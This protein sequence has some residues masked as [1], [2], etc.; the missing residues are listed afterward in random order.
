MADAAM[1]NCT[2][3]ATGDSSEALLQALVLL[4]SL[5][6]GCLCVGLAWLRSLLAKSA[7]NGAGAT[8]AEV[9]AAAAPPP[10]PKPVA[11][12]ELT[13]STAAA[14][15]EETGGCP[16][17]YDKPAPA[18][19]VTTSDKQALRMARVTSLYEDY[20]H[21][22][23]LTVV[24]DNP[25]TDNPAMEPCFAAAMHGIELAFIL[26]AEFVKDSRQYVVK[27][28]RMELVATDVVT[29]CGI[30][31]QI[32]DG[33]LEDEATVGANQKSRN[34]M[35]DFPF[36]GA[37]PTLTKEDTGF[38]RQSP[39][40]DMLI[41]AVSR[42][43]P[44]M[45]V[46]ERHSMIKVIR[47]I[48]GKIETSFS[49]WSVGIGW[50]EQLQQLRE[51]V[52]LAPLPVNAKHE[53]LN[54]A[55][56]VRPTSVANT[57]LRERYR[58]SEDF[59]FRSVHL[60]TEC[61][62]FI[63][64]DRLRSATD[65]IEKHGHWQNAAA[66]VRSAATILDY[67]GDH[68]MMLTSM[69]LRD[70]LHL[71]VEI[72]GTSGEGSSAVKSFR[73]LLEAL[74]TPLSDALLQGKERGE[75]DVNLKTA[76]LDLY[77]HPEREPGLY[78]YAKALEIVES[79]LLGGFYFRHFCLA[80]NVIGST[81]KGTM[82]K[83]VAAL[84]KTYEKQL[85]P[86]LD[87]TRAT[88]GAK[89][90]AELIQFKGRIMD[91]IERSRHSP[92]PENADDDPFDE[93][94][95]PMTKSILPPKTEVSP[96]VSPP[97]ADGRLQ[98]PGAS[99]SN[100]IVRRS[101]YSSHSVP[102]TLAE[103]AAAESKGMPD[104]AFLDHAWGK[105]PPAAHVAAIKRL[106]GLYAL[107][108]T[109]WDI[110]FMEIMPEAATHVKRLLGVGDGDSH[111]VEFCHN[112]HEITTRLLS[113]KLD[114]LLKV[115]SDIDE[116]PKTIRI[117]TT[118]TEF[119]SLTRQLNRFKELGERSQIQIE[120]VVIEPLATFPERFVAAAGVSGFDF[121]YASQCV[122]STQETIVPD[123]PTFITDLHAS[124]VVAWATDRPGAVFDALI[125]LDGYHGF[126]AIPTDL[127]QIDPAIPL[128]YI[129]GMLKHVASGANC[130]FMVAPAT[131]TL[132]P[133]L[134]GWLADPSVLA[135]ESDG[136]KLGSEV[137]YCPGL[138][139]MGGT[140]AFAPS[141]LTFNEV[142]RRWEERGIEV[143]RVHGHVMKLHDRFLAGL[144]VKQEADDSAPA[145]HGATA[146]IKLENLHSLL[147]RDSRS[148]TLVF[149]QPTA[150][151][152]KLV[153]ENLRKVHSI[154][155]DSRKTYVRV[156]FGFNHHPEEVD[157]LLR[158]IC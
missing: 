17:G 155:I 18:A 153:V 53:Y 78:G 55:V 99:R 70:Y 4:I 146:G 38:G 107:G 11:P 157:R 115:P 88:L 52:G 14:E 91:G 89:L 138:S 8:Q 112:S 33:E 58:H 84:K 7:A 144:K 145:E 92:S 90:D 65:Q 81:A 111:V 130:A 42:S 69:V 100:E 49:T 117:L 31:A 114:A 141:L 85:F 123:V 26:M 131:V 41:D 158:A 135:A 54:Y 21:L 35:Q 68:V 118:D 119:Y 56:L 24:W 133:M 108:N 64:L 93:A 106:Y 76:L 9:V 59:F 67:L 60:G 77:E 103:A 48:T 128:C 32:V 151:D 120:S 147:H 136:L 83:S 50:E 105:T 12:L 13:A 134:T 96:P 86:L 75:D 122:Y 116:A 137:G 47:N 97:K 121:V 22:H 80:S 43:F 150:A 126:G 95:K 57:L 73:P 140:P 113:T 143:T 152:A 132:R 139:L 82:K 74:F 28:P 51:S 2:A 94:P 46:P 5:C 71:K 15:V 40:L 1:A 16:F 110:L 98:S 102:K 149:D 45:S 79:S 72:E 23:D 34:L 10:N 61:W 30:L 37:P 29:Q 66:H 19:K 62:G 148:H 25:V 154:E 125:C 142:M 101:L 127:G 104:L 44:V 20:I 3:P 124:C 109:T 6:L 63:A 27:R 129:S 36:D 156:G 39:G 87:I